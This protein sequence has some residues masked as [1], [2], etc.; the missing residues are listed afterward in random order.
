MK[1]KDIAVHPFPKK[2]TLE[3]R[4][5]GNHK[6]FFHCIDS[7]EKK[8][9]YERI[10]L[11][12]DDYKKLKADL[13]SLFIIVKAGGGLVLNEKDKGLFIYRRGHWDL[14]KGKCDPGETRKATAVREVQEETGVTDLV[15][16]HLIMK[17]RHVYKNRMGKRVLKITNWYLMHAPEQKLHPE[18][19]EQIEKA[20][21][22]ELHDFLENYYP[23]FHTIHDVIEEYLKLTKLTT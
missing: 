20:K 22:L 10:I 14:P 12:A 2:K 15:R 6:T 16:D 4:Y 3:V 18:E 9:P 21:W 13:R 1:S 19:R 11:F 23:T 17:T 7:L 5:S 8:S